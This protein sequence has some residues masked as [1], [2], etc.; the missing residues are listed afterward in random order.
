VSQVTEGLK[1]TL[2]NTVTFSSTDIVE[3]ITR[4]CFYVDFSNNKTNL[5]L[6]H[7]KERSVKLELFYFAQKKN[8]AKIEVLEMQDLLSDIFTTSLKITEDYYISIHSCDFETNK[9]DGYLILSLD[10]NTLETLDEEGTEQLEEL[11]TNI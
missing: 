5:M 11:D 2:Y 4:P 8:N 1:D 6:K 10:L 9:K 3:K 7:S